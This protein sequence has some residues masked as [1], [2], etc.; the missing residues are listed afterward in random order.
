LDYIEAYFHENED[1][2]ERIENAAQAMG[3]GPLVAC[4]T[5]TNFSSQRVH[6]RKSESFDDIHGELTSLSS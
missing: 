1:E 3:Y 6:C 5:V 4:R 2:L